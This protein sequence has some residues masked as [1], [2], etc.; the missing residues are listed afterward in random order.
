MV[1]HDFNLICSYDKYY[2][3]NMLVELI[4]KQEDPPPPPL[5]YYMLD[6]FKTGGV[7]ND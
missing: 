7:N 4:S 1:L 2:C 6:L 5:P 3:Y